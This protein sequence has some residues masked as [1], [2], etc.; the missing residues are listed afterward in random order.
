MELKINRELNNK[1]VEA[2]T[3][4]KE[5]TGRYR[6]KAS[7]ISHC[8]EIGFGLFN[9]GYITFPE[10]PPADIQGI[11]CTD[12]FLPVTKEAIKEL[13]Q[14]LF[15]LL[16][17]EIDV[18]EVVNVLVD[19]ALGDYITPYQAI[20]NHKKLGPVSLAEDG[21]LIPV[22]DFFKTENEKEL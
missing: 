22:P 6:S 21:E 7:I 4:I 17:R 16:H 11:I 2:Q 13:R 3:I 18:Q 8:T 15:I 20:L 10:N 9:A 19:H 12:K 14:D 1:I 5:A